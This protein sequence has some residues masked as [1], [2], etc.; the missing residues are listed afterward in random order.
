MLESCAAYK[1]KSHF[2]V[3]SVW[4]K[5][6]LTTKISTYYRDNPEQRR[7]SKIS[8]EPGYLPEGKDG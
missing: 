3:A 1:A 7:D 2:I 8:L 5:G 4:S 6:Q